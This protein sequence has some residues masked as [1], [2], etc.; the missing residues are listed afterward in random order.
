[1]SK[2]PEKT[3]KKIDVAAFLYIQMPQGINYEKAY[4]TFLKNTAKSDRHVEV[5]IEAHG[6]V[7]E[8]TINE[9]LIKLGFNVP[10]HIPKI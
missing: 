4:A 6:Q 9:M 3:G 1:M 10:S 5:M 7:R 2:T 8:F